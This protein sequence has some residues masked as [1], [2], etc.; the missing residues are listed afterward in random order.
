MVAASF[1]S[2]SKRRGSASGRVLLAAIAQNLR[3]LAKSVEL[4]DLERWF[5]CRECDGRKAMVSVRWAAEW[6]EK[7]TA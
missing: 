6:K 1:N 5:R 4:M 7:P 3:K 2:I